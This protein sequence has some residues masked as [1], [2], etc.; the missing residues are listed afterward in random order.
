MSVN[1]RVIPDLIPARMLNEFAYC[2]RLFHIEYV[3][4]DFAPNQDTLEGA[5]VHRRVEDETGRLPPAEELSA[6]DHIAAR[7]V[8]LSA[9]LLGLIARMDVLEGAEGAVRPVDY[10]KGSPGPSGPWEPEVVQLCAQGLVLRENGYRCDEGVLYYAGTKQRHTLRFD[11][12]LIARTLDLLGRLREVAQ[13]PVPPPPLV[14]SPKCPRCSLVGIC[15]PDEV[16]VLRDEPL[17][18]VRRLAPA[19]DN[20]GPL[21]VLDQ[22]AMVGKSGEQVIVRK[23]DGEEHPVRL[24]D[25]S[26]LCLYGN[27]GVSAQAIRGLAEREIPVFHYTRGGWLAAITTGLPHRNV[28]LRSRQYRIADDDALSLALAR[29]FVVGKIRNQ[30]IL[31]RRNARF[32]ADRALQELARLTRAAHQATSAELL[33]GVEGM[34]AR[35]YFSTFG[36]L[37]REPMGFDFEAR[38]RRPPSDPINALLSFLYSLLMKEC[39]HALLAVGLDPFRGFYHRLRYGRPSLALDLAEEFRPLLADSVVLTL[40]NNRLVTTGDF[41]VRG[42]SCALTDS[43]RRTV[44]GTFEQRIDTLVRHPLF[45]YSLS[46]RRVL[47]LQARLLARRV[48]GELPG[49]RPFTTR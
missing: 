13:D 9:P 24:I 25:T 1:V 30:R 12:P 38:V 34:A 5:L 6:E 44:I 16:N 33:L 17:T 31:L 37:I 46:Y 11:E 42:A 43:G 32:D 23:R 18:E 48:S 27:V 21:Y 15:L 40:V 26:Q 36:Q 39:V 41:I 2:P 4:G 45:G 29:S 10:K 19:R 3:Q 49:Y 8:L 35:T 14:D 47:E 22:G 20:A 28:E 7:S